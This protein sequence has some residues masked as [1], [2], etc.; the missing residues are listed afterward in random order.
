[1]SYF[2]H[3]LAELLAV[4]ELS[5]SQFLLIGHERIAV[6]VGSSIGSV[7]HRAGTATAAAAAA[8][9]T[10]LVEILQFHELFLEKARQRR[11]PFC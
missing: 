1:M 11:R 6:V 8:R 7:G 10:F 2:K 4:V 9:T 3:D 5:Q